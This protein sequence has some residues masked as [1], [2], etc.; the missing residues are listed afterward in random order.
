MGEK[1]LLYIDKQMK[2][3]KMEYDLKFQKNI[4]VIINFFNDKKLTFP[5]EKLDENPILLLMQLK[6]ITDNIDRANY[7]EKLETIIYEMI[8]KRHLAGSSNLTEKE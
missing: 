5:E 4:D 1:K 2:D 7:I 3:L 8:K 6:E